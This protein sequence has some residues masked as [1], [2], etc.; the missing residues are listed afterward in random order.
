MYL[1]SYGCTVVCLRQLFAQVLD[2][3]L[4]VDRLHALA[5]PALRKATVKVEYEWRIVIQGAY[6]GQVDAKVVHAWLCLLGYP[7]SCIYLDKFSF[8]ICLALALE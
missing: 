6:S 4:A 2:I 8:I 5:T 7:D 1:R 3:H